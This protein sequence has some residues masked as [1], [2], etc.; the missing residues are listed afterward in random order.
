MKTWKMQ[1]TE[2]TEHRLCGTLAEPLAPFPRN[3]QI[4]TRL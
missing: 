3:G 1:P 4:T 2:V